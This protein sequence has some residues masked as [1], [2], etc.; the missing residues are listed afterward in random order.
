MKKI[1][2]LILALH[3]TLYTLHG[4]CAGP[5]TTGA[6]F[7]K[8]GVGSR[9]V[10][11]GEAFVA[12]ADDINA[13]YWNPSG[14][15]MAEGKQVIF[16]HTEWFQAIRYEYLAYCQPAFGGTIGTGITYLYITDIERRDIA[17]ALL[18][19]VPANDLAIVVSYAKM[20]SERLNLG[21]TVKIINQQLDDKS[22]FGIAADL[23]MQY[24]LNKEGLILGLALQNMGCEAPFI[25]EASS[26]PMNLKA[27]IA[28]KSAD[29]KL[30]LS[31]DLN[32]SIL[33]SIW[34]VGAGIEYW[35]HPVFAIR[36]GYKYNSAINNTL[37]ALAGLTCGVG[38]KI[39]ILGIDYALVPYGDLGYTH[40]ISLIAKF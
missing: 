2:F 21:G 26:L 10:A 18:G 27:G 20:L 14:L 29:S 36:A 3:L 35:V 4:S 32:Y 22:A 19:S 39:G 6:T 28:N 15:S 1:I 24:K 34:A 8:L 38:F 31:A 13:L 30:T 23:G 40:R 5:G 37:G 7:L 17:G 33:D 11:M 25:T 9:P 12:A 16:A